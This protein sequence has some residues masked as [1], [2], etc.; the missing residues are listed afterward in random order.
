MR[1]LILVA[2]CLC[3]A[4]IA[5]AIEVQEPQ[6]QILKSIEFSSIDDQLRALGAVKFIVDL[7]A[8]RDDVFELKARREKLTLD[9]GR[10]ITT[11]GYNEEA[12][13]MIGAVSPISNVSITGKE[14][15]KILALFHDAENHIV[16]PNRNHI[17]VFDLDF[18]PLEF[19][20]TP[21]LPPNDV[22]VD[23][24]LLIDVSG[25]MASAL[26]DV[27]RASSNFLSGLPDFTR[28][29]VFTFGSSVE[30]LT[31]ADP[32][33]RRPCPESLNVLTGGLTANGTTALHRVIKE[34]LEDHEKAQSQ[35]PKLTIILTDGKDTENP[36]IT[37]E[38]LSAL[39]KDSNSKV[40]IFWAGLYNP[41]YLKGLADI[42]SISGKQI[43]RDLEAFF[44]TIGMSINGLQTIAIN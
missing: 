28:C 41:D 32:A 16:A 24:S 11:F 42:E 40:L 2:A 36:E 26:P 17:R 44:R 1:Y 43:T 21:A 29:S 18:K 31:D 3:C 5:P 39:K 4:Q 8:A 15:G 33:K 10:N 12:G 34:S 25:S 14:N 13:V 35:L 23:V 38:K 27:T 37:V 7:G 19:E 9:D 22:T 30:R 6:S 20:Y